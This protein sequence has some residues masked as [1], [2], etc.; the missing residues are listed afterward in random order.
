MLTG[1]LAEQSQYLR[2][3]KT[4]NVLV[5][6]LLS[7][8]TLKSD[9]LLL[10]TLSGLPARPDQ[11]CPG[12]QSEV[13]GVAMNKIIILILATIF[14]SVISRPDTFVVAKLPGDK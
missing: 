7:S 1:N 12:W 9:P 10:H 2:T 4:I 14:T 13:W 3:L 6:N 11:L 5:I 8:Y